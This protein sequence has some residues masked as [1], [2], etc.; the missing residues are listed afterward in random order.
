MKPASIWGI[1]CLLLAG[2]GSEQDLDGAW[3]Q[4]IRAGGETHYVGERIIVEDG[5]RVVIRD[6]A[7]YVD[8]LER[9]G[10]DLSYRNGAPYYLHVVHDRLL[11]GMG[12]TGNPIRFVKLH[13]RTGF[14][15]GRL[16]ISSTTVG[17][18]R[19]EQDVCAQVRI[20][21]FVWVDQSE[22]LAPVVVINA[23]YG[24]HRLTLELKFRELVNGVHPLVEFE[25]FVKG[26]GPGVMP[27]IQSEAFMSRIGNDVLPVVAGS[28]DLRN[29][30]PD[31]LDI[32]GRL[33]LVTGERVEFSTQVTITRPPPGS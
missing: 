17:D 1:A 31:S 24:A 12:D 22:R 26:S 27:W 4:E 15:S 5:N 20:M 18:L 33:E 8:E 29:V 32:Q 30:R 11:E 16:R 9:S 6:C 25:D 10:N 14:A 21:R 2:C 19:A 3:F 28:V 23:P 7:G 13:A